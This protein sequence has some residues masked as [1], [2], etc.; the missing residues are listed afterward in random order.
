MMIST[1]IS[2]VSLN[3][4]PNTTTIVEHAH[5]VLSDAHNVHQAQFP[6]ANNAQMVT[7]RLMEAHA[8]KDAQLDNTWTMDIAIHAHPIVQA[9][10]QLPLAVLVVK[11]YSSRT[12]LHVW[13]LAH[14]D[15]SPKTTE[16]VAHVQ[17]HA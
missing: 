2:N 7:S 5:N 6:H 10:I 8:H 15:T 4:Q 14:Q 12:D 16:Y 11:A 9:V 1:T 13:L 3:A 17:H